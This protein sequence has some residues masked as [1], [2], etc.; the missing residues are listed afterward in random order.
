MILVRLMEHFQIFKL[1][2]QNSIA[3]EAIRSIALFSILLVSGCLSTSFER[4]SYSGLSDQAILWEVTLGDLKPLSDA[5]FVKDVD[6]LAA[7]GIDW[8]DISNF[9]TGC[10]S[11]KLRD[12]ASRTEIEIIHF[13]WLQNA[14]RED[15]A[16]DSVIEA[17][18]EE[19]Y[20][21]ALEQFVGGAD[22]CIYEIHRHINNL[23]IP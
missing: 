12:N 15:T 7:H 5:M 2:R 19:H 20:R 21:G 11:S 18:G 14:G 16:V 22:D 10:W 8:R 3:Q 6:R 1:G 9:Y 4:S 23:K 17:L 13:I